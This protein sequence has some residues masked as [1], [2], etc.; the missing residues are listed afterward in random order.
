M[1]LLSDNSRTHADGFLFEFGQPT[2]D[3]WMYPFNLTPG[4][5]ASA[6]VFGSLG[7][8]SGV[9]SRHGQFLVGFDF[10]AQTATNCG[11]T[12]I[13]PAL[14]ATN[15]GPANYLLRRVRFTATVNRDKTFAYDPTPD[16]YTT[17]LPT[18]HPAYTPDA[19]TG[20]P[21]ELFGASYRNGW[22]AATFW[23]DG[24][25]G[26]SA[27]GQRNAFASAYDTNGVLVDVSNNVG[28]TN[29]A[30][31]SFEVHPFAVG[32]AT[33]LN[34]GDA[35]PGGTKLVF[36]LNLGDPLVRQYVQEALNAGRLRLMIASLHTSSFG[37]Q[38]AWP[39]FFTRDNILGTPPT[40]EIEG[41]LVEPTDADGDGLPD[42]WE[43]FYFGVLT[44]TGS[45]D[46]DGDG[47]SNADEFTAGTDPTDPAS[48]LRVISFTRN[49][50]GS[51]Q[52]RFP[53]VASHRP[54]LETSADT[55]NWTP[56]PNPALR[57]YNQSGF[58]EWSDD[59]VTESGSARFYRVRNP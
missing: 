11:D 25:F 23:E 48:V 15:R 43:R 40:L 29:A 37:G 21:V 19:D 50:D 17:Y 49:A 13:L 5:R 32:L 39:D 12:T 41:V 24:A 16:A 42:D 35:V 44:H 3:R 18:T 28:K 27:P 8:D 33:N 53:C 2:L 55:V 7:D 45:E 58:I 56:V 4:C 36:D 14:L 38:P 26:G 59:S 30:F 6:P 34:P 51:F 22:E 47:V 1:V 10:I 52:L 9:D 31:P 54:V 46:T 57:F 20:R